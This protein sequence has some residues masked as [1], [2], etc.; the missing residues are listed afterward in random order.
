VESM[1]RI[2]EELLRV[3]GFTERIVVDAEFAVHMTF[4]ANA[5]YR[6]ARSSFEIQAQ[7]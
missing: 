7:A 3:E 2:V 6:S 1:R 4:L 5:G